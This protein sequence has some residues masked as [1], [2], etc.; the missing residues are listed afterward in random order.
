M[1]G[2]THFN[3]KFFKLGV[4]LAIFDMAKYLLFCS[5]MFDICTWL[6]VTFFTPEVKYSVQLFKLQENKWLGFGM[7]VR[8]ENFNH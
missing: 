2:S 5:T 8:A 4:N 6:L 7:G 3:D 1:T